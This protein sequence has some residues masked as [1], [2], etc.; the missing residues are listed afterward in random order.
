MIKKNNWSGFSWNFVIVTLLSLICYV[1]AGVWY[2]GLSSPWFYSSILLELVLLL[3]WVFWAGSFWSKDVHHG[4]LLKEGKPHGS[5]L[6]RGG[7]SWYP[8]FLYGLVSIPFELAS[9]EQIGTI[10]VSKDTPTGVRTGKLTGNFK[11]QVLGRENA[12]HGTVKLV[13]ETIDKYNWIHNV[14]L[15]ILNMITI[16]VENLTWAQ[17][18]DENAR[19]QAAVQA[20]RQV[21]QYLAQFGMEVYSIELDAFAPDNLGQQGL[22]LGSPQA[23]AAPS[24]ANVQ[25]PNQVLQM[26]PETLSK[27]IEAALGPGATAQERMTLMKD[28]LENGRPNIIVQ[29]GKRGNKKKGS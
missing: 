4:L 9:H 5:E 17:L 12:D 1:V 28:M 22:A 14:K 18:L 29:G 25:Y 11:L 8:P 21:N 26:E 2:K 13:F 23:P 19:D 10:Q 6:L 27:F 15:R 16:G 3:G 24:S 7:R 20:K